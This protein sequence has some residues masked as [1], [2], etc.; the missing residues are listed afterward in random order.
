MLPFPQPGPPDEKEIQKH[1]QIYAKAEY[2]VTKRIFK[3]NNLVFERND[4]TMGYVCFLGRDSQTYTLLISERV[5]GFI[6]HI[7]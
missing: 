6:S 2:V 7:T 5:R 3:D 4:G 1:Q